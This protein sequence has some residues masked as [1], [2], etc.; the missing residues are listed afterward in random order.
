[1]YFNGTVKQ[2]NVA[3][4][5]GRHEYEYILQ[6]QDQLCWAAVAV[7]IVQT[8]KVQNHETAADADGLLARVVRKVKRLPLS[9]PRCNKPE[10][11]LSK[12][13]AKVGRYNQQAADL[14]LEGQSV[15]AL[16]KIIIREINANRPVGARIKITGRLHYVTIVGYK[17]S[18]AARTRNGPGNPEVVVCDP[19]QGYRHLR[20]NRFC[21]EGYRWSACRVIDESGKSVFTPRACEQWFR[22]NIGGDPGNFWSEDTGGLETWCRT[23]AGNHA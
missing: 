7:C 14:G 15:K 11:S 23:K 1:V 20:L 9:N 6:R 17:Y 8:F 10:P 12:V 5:P 4:F 19:W 21:N 2:K 18:T 16:A 13:L 22:D 3:G